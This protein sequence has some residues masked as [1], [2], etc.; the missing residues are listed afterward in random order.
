MEIRKLNTLRALAAL[1]VVLSHYSNV[2]MLW[3]ELLGSAAGQL[4]VML[5]FILSG[6]LMS[7]LYLEHAYDKARAR[8]FLVARVARV[9]PLFVAVVLLS[10]ALHK[11]GVKYI[12]YGVIN[13]PSLISHLTLLSGRDVLWTIAPEVQF[14]LLF[15]PLWMLYTKRPAYLYALMALVFLILAA[16]HFPNPIWGHRGYILDTKILIALP[17]FFVGIVLGR[18]YTYR[19]KLAPWQSAWYLLAL[20][21]IFLLYPQVFE[22]VFS[23]QHGTWQD[24]MVLLVMGLAFFFLVFLVPDNNRLLANPVGDFLG[25]IS[26]SWYF[27]HLP[28]LRLM[29]ENV[30]QY[31]ALALPIFMALSLL[32]AYLS[33]RL[34]EVPSRR[35]IRRKFA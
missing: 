6:F 7:H 35:A 24:P 31:P 25:K 17:Y 13:V 20:L 34:I 28:V 12:F 23:V 14:Y 27:L 9:M 4:G 29:G 19:Q 10:Y 18:L 2:S 21:L 1:I 32:V 22:A 3:G 15:V 11:L 30:S 26:Y 16:M 5:F 8:Q 33:Y